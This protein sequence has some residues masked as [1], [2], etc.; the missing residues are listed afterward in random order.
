MD[1]TSLTCRLSSR[2]GRERHPFP[3]R[4]LSPEGDVLTSLGPND[5]LRRAPSLG[6]L[7]SLSARHACVSIVGSCAPIPC[8]SDKVPP[9]ERCSTVSIV[10][11]HKVL[12]GAV[13]LPIEELDAWVLAVIG[14]AWAPFLYW[15]GRLSGTRTGTSSVLTTTY[16]RVFLD[17]TGSAVPVPATWGGGDLELV[18]PVNAER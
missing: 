13:H 4:V 5:P 6:H 18:L 12:G 9:S 11:N 8:G 7:P 15:A 1:S 17:E 14:D 2:R 10:G 16:H 3:C